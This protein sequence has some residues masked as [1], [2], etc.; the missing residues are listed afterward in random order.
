MYRYEPRQND[1]VN[2]T[3][4]CDHGRLNYKWINHA[5]RLKDVLVL[6]QKSSWTVALNE[7]AEKLKTISQRYAVPE[8]IG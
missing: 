8:Q 5:D 3:W 1:A 2:S 7:I 4:M 6:G